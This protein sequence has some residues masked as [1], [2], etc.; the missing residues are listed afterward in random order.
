[1]PK[2]ITVTGLDITTNTGV[3]FHTSI[4]HTSKLPL[5]D[6]NTIYAGAFN[7]LQGKLGWKKQFNVMSVELFAGIDNA[8]NERYSL[9]NDI[10]AF[11][12]DSPNSRYFNPSPLR[13][14]FGGLVIGF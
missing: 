1:M 10:N 7:I 5:N 2:Y 8:L 6:A 4:N 3:Y 12:L 14:Y 9:G 13:N 11:P